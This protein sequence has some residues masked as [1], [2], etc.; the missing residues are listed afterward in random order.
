MNELLKA[1]LDLQTLLDSQ[2]WPFCIIGGIA[3]I[4]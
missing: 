4:R 3:L 2:G 1:A